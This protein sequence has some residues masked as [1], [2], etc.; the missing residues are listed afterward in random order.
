MSI[1]ITDENYNTYK[2]LFE[3]FW[4]HYTKLLPP[5]LNVSSPIEVLNQFEARGKSYGKRSLQSGLG[6]LV[7]IAQNVPSNIIQA[8]DKDL[9]D[10]NLPDF[11]SFK[12]AILDTP[13][14]VLKRGKI[15]NSDEYYIIQELI[16]E[17]SNN[18]TEDKRKRLST[19]ISEFED[20]SKHVS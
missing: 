4:S 11:N 2:A 13:N 9:K 20:K 17:M 6:D 19:Y 16:S 12:A 5:E 14:K 7:F 15:K 10:K 18:L 3:V 1:K 8:I